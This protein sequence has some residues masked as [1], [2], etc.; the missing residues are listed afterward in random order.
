MKLAEVFRTENKGKLT[1]TRL[2]NILIMCSEIFV[3]EMGTFEDERKLG[4][5]FFK[6]TNNGEYEQ[7]KAYFDLMEFQKEYTPFKN[8]LSEEDKQENFLLQIINEVEG[9][10]QFLLN[11]K[12][13]FSLTKHQKEYLDKLCLEIEQIPN[14]KYIKF[15]C[16]NETGLKLEASKSLHAFKKNLYSE[17]YIEVQNCIMKTIKTSGVILIIAGSN[18][19]TPQRAYK[20][21][22]EEN[23]YSKPSK[24]PIKL[25][26]KYRATEKAH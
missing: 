1:R 9:L 11:Q 19:L 16:K 12:L 21:I 22:L 10:N 24:T 25:S 23:H 4:N 20:Y 7:T 18:G 5:T 8:L 14:T 17:N 15:Y 13:W 26:K 3:K 2:K 6:I